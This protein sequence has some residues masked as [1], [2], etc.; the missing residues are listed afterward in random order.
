M[1]KLFLALVLISSI[2]QACI[3]DKLESSTI[4]FVKGNPK[5]TCFIAGITTAAV[6]KFVMPKVIDVSKKVYNWIKVKLGR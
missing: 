2:S 4:D 5:K 3:L 6:G 1:K